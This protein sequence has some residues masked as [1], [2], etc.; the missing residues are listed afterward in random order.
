MAGNTTAVH[1][2]LAYLEGEGVRRIFGVP[3]GPLTALF[4]ALRERNRIQFVLAKHEEGAALMAPSLRARRRRARRVLRDDRAGR[5]NAL[6]GIACA[7]ADARPCS[8]SPGRWRPRSFG[9]GALQESTRVRRRPRRDVQAGDQALGDGP[10]GERVPDAP[11][12]AMRTALSRAA[13]AG[14]PQPAR[15]RREGVDDEDP[16]EPRRFAPPARPSTTRRRARG[17]AARRA[18]SAPASSRATASPRRGATAELVELASARHPRRHLAQGQ[19]RVPRVRTRS[20]SACS[21]SAA[22]RAPRHACSR[23]TTSTSLLVVGTRA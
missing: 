6:T 16:V 22:T 18:R 9:K 23:A 20:R 4:E 1:A 11:R 15:R 7:Y 3:G 10:H 8:C 12:L 19:G 2:L 13:R 17:R 21:A 5:T 14:A